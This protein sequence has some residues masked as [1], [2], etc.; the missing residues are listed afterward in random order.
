MI[1]EVQ[2]YPCERDVRARHL[3]QRL[4]TP[5][6][7]MGLQNLPFFLVFK[8]SLH[9]KTNPGYIRGKHNRFE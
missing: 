9:G 3:S 5:Q 7:E 1:F 8:T 6:P 2:E 4:N